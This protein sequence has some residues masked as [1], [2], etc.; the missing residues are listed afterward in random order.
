VR[1]LA[2]SSRAHRPI[3]YTDWFAL[4]EDAG[5]GIEARE[6]LATFLTQ[7][8]RSPVV[9]R[10]GEPGTYFLDH[11]APQRLAEELRLLHVELARLHQG[12]Q[13]IDG[14]ISVREKRVDLTTKISQVERAYHEALEALGHDAAA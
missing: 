10:A 7:V 9:L 1:L 12:Q 3:H 13:T 8:S 2:G 11:E 6:P 5:Y 14:V 4:L